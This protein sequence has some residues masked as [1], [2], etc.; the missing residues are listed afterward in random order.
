MSMRKTVD[1]FKSQLEGFRDDI[2]EDL[3][4][5]VKVPYNHQMTP[6][7]HLSLVNQ[8]DRRISVTPY[9]PSLL[10]VIET[11]LKQQGFDAYKFSK[12]TVVV[13]VPL[14]DGQSQKKVEAQIKKLAEEAKIAIRNIRKKFRQKNKDNDEELQALTDKA[15]EEIG[16]LG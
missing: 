3:I 15:I 1:L 9:D 12:T 4:A 7:Q 13:N 2:N 10:A 8:K 14:R 11:E 16:N 5:T 6:L